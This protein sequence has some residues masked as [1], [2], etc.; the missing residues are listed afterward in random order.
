MSTVVLFCKFI[1][2]FHEKVLRKL[3]RNSN[4]SLLVFFY[5]VNHDGNNIIGC[6]HNLK[7]SLN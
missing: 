2:Y 3:T 7:T 5:C 1:S 4:S 6:R